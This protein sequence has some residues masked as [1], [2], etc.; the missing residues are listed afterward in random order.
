M[1][2]ILNKSFF[3]KSG[4]FSALIFSFILAGCGSKKLAAQQ[5]SAAT[6]FAANNPNIRY[7][8]RVDFSNP[9]KPQIWAPGA[10]IKVRFKGPALKLLVKN[11]DGN[12]KTRCYLEIIIDHRELRR[13]QLS[14]AADTVVIAKGLKNEVH[15]ATI[16]KDTEGINSIEIEGFFANKLL[17]LSSKP[18]RK[19]QFIGDSITCGF[20]ND[21]SQ[22][23]CSKGAWY[24]HENAY[25]S[26]G[27][28]AARKLH[29]RWALASVSGIGL[30]HS[31]CGMKITMPQVYGHLDMR[32][33]SIPIKFDRTPPDVVAICLGQ[34]DGIQD[35]TEFT[36]TY[37]KFIER[38]RKHYPK[39]QIVCLT[40]PMADA[41]LNQVLK[42][43]LKGVVQKM[44]QKGDKKVSKYFFKKRY[45]NGCDGHPSMKQDKLMA[46]EVSTYLRGLMHW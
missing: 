23:P 27:L 25:M 32:D 17:P 15:T 40:S 14:S 38:L 31:C 36:G 4:L 44:H 2:F 42:N 6:F 46:Q 34:N 41:K 43:Y 22:K 45:H 9:K 7:V 11:R 5:K 35:S 12:G 20:G 30:I 28:T 29:A 26:F 33:D 39:A 24:D 13:I 1:T 19:I 37:V 18:G 21:T 10:Y 16:V 8:G 3:F